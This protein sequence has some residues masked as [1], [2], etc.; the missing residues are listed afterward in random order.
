MMGAAVVKLFSGKTVEGSAVKITVKSGKVKVD[1]ANV[2]V[3]RIGGDAVFVMPARAAVGRLVEKQTDAAFICGE[4]LRSPQGGEVHLTACG[5]APTLDL[6]GLRALREL[7]TLAPGR[8][9][10]A[11][12][13]EGLHRGLEESDVTVYVR[14][15][16]GRGLQRHL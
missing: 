9:G 13:R 8:R 12:F 16:L 3:C 10:R 14:S 15:G 11:P 7:E 1:E 5:S 4:A 2:V 6:Q